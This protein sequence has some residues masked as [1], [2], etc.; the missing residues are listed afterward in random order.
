MLACVRLH[1]KHDLQSSRSDEEALQ[2]RAS[3]V[4]ATMPSGSVGTILGHENKLGLIHDSER[5]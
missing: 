2:D 5:R 1:G 3:A 4:R